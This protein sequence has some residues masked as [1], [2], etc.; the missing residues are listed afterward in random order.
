MKTKQAP[1]PVKHAAKYRVFLVEDHPVTREGFAQ[2]INY[3]PDLEVCGQTGAAGNAMSAIAELKPDLAII[4]ISLA[5]SSGL[6]LIKNLKCCQPSVPVLVLSTHDEALYGQ[7]ALRSGA[8]G[9]V[10]KQAPTSEVMNAIRDVIAGEIY[11]SNAMRTRVVRQQFER[12]KDP[13]GADIHVLSDRELEIFA[14]LGHGN[15]TRQIS[16]KLHLSISTVETHRAHIKEKLE[17]TNAVELVRR[18][19]EWVN[20]R[21]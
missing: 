21:A 8:R 12:P 14:L 4:D 18:A 15:T 9:Y 7:R 19:V 10:M 1:G 20:H 17:L 2:L 6:E 11:L 3:Q 16:A 5:D 13:E